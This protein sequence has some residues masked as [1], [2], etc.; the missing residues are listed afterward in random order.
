MA[1]TSTCLSPACGVTI[2]GSHKKCPH[3]GWTMNSARLIRI[4]GVVLILCGVVLVGLMGTITWNLLPMLLYPEK[5]I[6]AGDFTGTPQQADTFLTLF[7]AVL[8]FGFL[9]LVNGIYMTVSG[10]QSRVFVIISLVA[11][12]VLF[13]LAWGIRRGFVI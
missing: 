8:A 2:E 5:A 9:S 13:M 1:N 12:A 11:G 4:R 10:R 3:C 6:A 7:L